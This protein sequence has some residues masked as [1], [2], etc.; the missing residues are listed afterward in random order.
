MPELKNKYAF[1]DWFKLFC[2]FLVVCIHVEPFSNYYLF[3]K[4]FSVLTRIA[5]PFFFTITAYFFC[6]KG[7]TW[8]QC[9]RYC[10]RMLLLY[11]VWS[12][13]Y[14]V[15]RW[16]IIGIPDKAFLKSFF[17]TGYIHLWFLQA[18]IVAAILMTIYFSLLKNRVRLFYF[19]ACLLFVFGCLFS[20]YGPLVCKVPLFRTIYEGRVINF[21]G[22][23]NGIF[24]GLPFFAIG[25]FIANGGTLPKLK[26]SVLG[27]IICFAVLAIEGVVAVLILHTSQTI[28]WFSVAPLTFFICSACFEIQIKNQKAN[29]IA[30]FI[31]KCTT[32]IYCVHPLLILLFEPVIKNRV[33]LTILVF[34]I[35][36]ILAIAFFGI[37]NRLSQKGEAE[38]DRL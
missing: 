30:S 8:K 35:S 20:T 16:L 31:R 7:I 24:Y 22:T 19:I 14:Y 2:A 21:I 25:F 32:G 33:V 17:V 34:C 23:R 15:S 5:V 10:K 27:I 4:A 26:T 13:I 36:M 28:L 6:L 38:N 1:I 3:D 9:F 37:K 11:A 18:S 12:A 29:D